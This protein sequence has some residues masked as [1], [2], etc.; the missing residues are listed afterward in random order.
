MRIICPNCT[1]Q[2][3][4]PEDRFRTDLDKATMRCAKCEVVFSLK[5]QGVAPI[6]TTRKSHN[7]LLIG[8]LAVIL[9]AI[10]FMLLTYVAMK[11][12]GV[13]AL[14][15]LPEQVEVAL[16]KDD[17]SRADS[18]PADLA[19]TLDEGYKLV[20]KDKKPVLVVKGEVFNPG[21]TRR[22]RILLEG[23]IVDA[24]GNV[25]FTTRAPCGKLISNR[26]L[27]RTKRGRFSR[28]FVRKKA[29]V[30]CSLDPGKK[31]KFQMIFDDIPP[32]YDEEYTV[33]VKTL[34]SGHESEE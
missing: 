3:E 27:K 5:D 11:N 6:K 30:D 28:L 24:G 10:V 15:K 1:E 12:E 20:I 7:R 26:K 4:V 33:K 14:D 2:Y 17:A 22:T 18:H 29:Y 31:K 16:A 9:V 32:D 21:P 34:F 8:I 23:R 25:R 13:L 19:V